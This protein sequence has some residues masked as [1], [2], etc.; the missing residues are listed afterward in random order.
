MRIQPADA[1]LGTLCKKLRGEGPVGRIGSEI[2]KIVT[3]GNAEQGVVEPHLAGGLRRSHSSGHRQCLCHV[4][5]NVS[6][7]RAQIRAPGQV[8]DG[9]DDIG[10]ARPRLMATMP[11]R[12]SMATTQ[13][14]PKRDPENSRPA[15]ATTKPPASRSEKPP[16]AAVPT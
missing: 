14:M 15:S 1:L 13:M 2:A 5:G 6:A 9:S 16:P 4:G 7:L 10:G 11:Q 8:E 3:E 12:T